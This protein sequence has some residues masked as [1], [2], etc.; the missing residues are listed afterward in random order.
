[1]GEFIFGK[2][3]NIHILVDQ[4]VEINKV[5]IYGT[6][7]CPNLTSWAFYGPSS[8]LKEKFAKIPYQT[9]ILLTHCPPKHGQQG[10]VLQPGWDYLK[11]FGCEELEDAIQKIFALKS[12][13]TIILSGHIHSGNHQTEVEGGYIYRNVSLLDEDYKMTYSPDYFTYYV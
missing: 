4:M 12:L 2:D 5:R 6:S 1:M 13:S 8:L 3:S 10:V 9:N 11:N 7:W